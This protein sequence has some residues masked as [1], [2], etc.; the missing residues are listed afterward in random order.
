M[1]LPKYLR[2]LQEA[3]PNSNDFRS[4]DDVP[5]RQF[6]VRFVAN[7]TDEQVARGWLEGL[8]WFLSGFWVILS[9]SKC[10][11]SGLKCV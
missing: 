2:L 10:F 6:S 7:A 8:K 1:S 11:L 9:G 4:M 5:I 3:L